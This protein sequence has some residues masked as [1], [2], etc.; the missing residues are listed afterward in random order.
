MSPIQILSRLFKVSPTIA[1]FIF[2]GM[3]VFAAA[4]IVLSLGSDI[5]DLSVVAIYLVVLAAIATVLAF[6]LNDGLMRATI[7]W[8]C[9]TAFGG[10]TVGLFDSALQLSGRLPSLPCYIR[11]PVSHPEEC[12]A[13]FA[14]TVAEIGGPQQDTLDL[15]GIDGPETLWFAQLVTE[16]PIPHA[17]PTIAQSAKV[18]LH[19]TPDVQPDEV[20][21]LADNLTALDWPIPE[22][23][24]RGELVTNGPKRNE[25]RY[26]HPSDNEAA[27]ALA[28][29][30]Y[31]LSP[32]TPVSVRDFSR[33]GSFVPDGQFEIWVNALSPQERL[34]H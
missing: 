16:P 19:F 14:P 25:V 26:F 11:L 34:V 30:L 13:R 23:Q 8:I 12:M 15:P 32:D 33:L 4:A 6:I 17:D 29:T 7:C 2:A 24:A 28:E 9:I 3:G 27:L 18:F 5:S 22:G 31:A 20:E 21:A 1:A 10:W